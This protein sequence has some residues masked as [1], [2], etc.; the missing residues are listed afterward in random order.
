MNTEL[1]DLTLKVSPSTAEYANVNLSKVRNGH[2]GTHFD[3]MSKEFPLSYMELPAIVFD[4]EQIGND[5]EIQISD[6][7]D[8]LIP[9]GGA[10]LFKTNYIERVGYGSKK[11][12][13][14]HPQLSKQLIELL[15]RK[16]IAIIAVDFSGVRCGHE[17][18]E[19]DQYCADHGTFIVENVCNLSSVLKGQKSKAISLGTYPINFTGMTGLP[20][21]VVARL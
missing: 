15:L 1:I 21:R 19:A 12:F 20:C 11:Y 5:A 3:V 9:E 10:V 4:V 16:H 7:D 14:T 2:I 6:I 8:N 13:T 18:T 17:H